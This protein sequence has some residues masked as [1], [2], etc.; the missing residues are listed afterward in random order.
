MKSTFRKVRSCHYEGEEWFSVAFKRVGQVDPVYEELSSTSELPDILYIYIIF[1]HNRRALKKGKYLTIWN[2][3]LYRTDFSK[4]WKTKI[5]HEGKCFPFNIMYTNIH[6]D[7]TKLYNMI[8]KINVY[9][10]V[11]IVEDDFKWL[12]LV[13]LTVIHMNFLSLLTS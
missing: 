9:T 6:A 7:F 13:E 8:S 12:K 3:H 10:V 2:F 5:T 1:L 11:W 4:I